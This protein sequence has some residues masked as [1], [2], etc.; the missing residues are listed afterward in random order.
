MHMHLLHSLHHPLMH[1]QLGPVRRLPG[2]LM[3]YPPTSAQLLACGWEV[4][5][6]LACRGCCHSSPHVS[7]GSSQRC[8]RWRRVPCADGLQHS[9]V[10]SSDVKRPAVASICCSTRCCPTSAWASAALSALPLAI[11]AAASTTHATARVLLGGTC[12]TEDTAAPATARPPRGAWG[13]STTCEA[14]PS[15]APTSRTA[16]LA[17]HLPHATWQS[18]VRRSEQEV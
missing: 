13:G 3:E 12:S 15:S 16:V 7:Q 18:G 8:R 4:G 6:L 5:G 1:P 9:G 10:C 17:A 11:S 2:A 14:P